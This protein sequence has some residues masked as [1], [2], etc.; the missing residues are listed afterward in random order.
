MTIAS[1]LLLVAAVAADRAA[2]VRRN[3]GLAARAVAFVSRN[4]FAIFVG[5]VAM[6]EVLKSTGFT[7]AATSHAGLFRIARGGGRGARR[8]HRHRLAAEAAGAGHPGRQAVKALRIHAGPLRARTHRANGLRPQDVRTV[9]GAAGGPKGLILGPID[10]FL[11]G[12]WLPQIT[13]PVDLVGASIGAWRMANACLRRPGAA[14]EQFEHGYIRQHFE[15]PPGQKRLTAKQVSAQF[16]EA[17]AAST[18][19]ASARCCGIRA[20]G[21]M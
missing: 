9:P 6:L 1:L 20:T 12:E 2:P 19:A 21:C 14:F 17:C 18:A 10:R 8:L 16:G 4:T 15:L 13:Q 11:F 3:P 7:A 5:N